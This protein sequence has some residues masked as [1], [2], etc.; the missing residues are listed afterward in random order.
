MDGDA[1]SKVSYWRETGEN[2]L[3]SR[4]TAHDPKETFSRRRVSGGT[5]LNARVR[6]SSLSVSM[7]SADDDHDSILALSF[8]KRVGVDLPGTSLLL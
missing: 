8:L 7:H 1:R 2:M 4:F 3:S 6:R 5:H